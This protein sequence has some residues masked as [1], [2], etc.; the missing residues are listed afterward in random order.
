MMEEIS[1][2]LKMMLPSLSM[3]FSRYKFSLFGEK[4]KK[5]EMK[6]YNK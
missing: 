2:F 6:L 3:I 5:K 4:K 1:L